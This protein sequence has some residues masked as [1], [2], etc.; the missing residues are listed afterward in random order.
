MSNDFIKPLRE[1]IRLERLLF[2]RDLYILDE[3]LDRLEGQE[4]R[5]AELKA[6][7]QR[8]IELAEFWILRENRENYSDSEWKTWHS[9][10][11]GSNA[12][13]SART[14]LKEKQP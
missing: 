14:A 10:G 11:F 1:W 2:G 7:L 4:K 13:Q 3:A 5:I 6:D 12:M 9:L 8:M